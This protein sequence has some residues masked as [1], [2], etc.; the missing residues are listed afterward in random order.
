[1]RILFGFLVL[2]GM[3]GAAVAE[4]GRI[5]VSGHG[6]VDVT[7]DMAVLT[8]GVSHEAKDAGEAV[9]ETS[10]KAG[11]ILSRLDALGIEKRDVQ[12]S[13]L[14]LHPVHKRYDSG[15]DA[16][17]DAFRATNTVTVRVRDVSKLGTVLARVVQDGANQFNGLHFALQSPRPYEDDARRTAVA[18]ARAKAELYAAAAGVTLGDVLE[19]SEGGGQGPRPMPMMREAMMA[20]ASVPVAAGE[21]TV[22]A[23][24]TMVFS[25]SQ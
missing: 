2:V 15:N 13:N 14:T 5:V 7:P 21:L 3:C 16:K 11:E 9:S 20:D 19:I 17:I 25:V 8:L 10:A 22:R 18:D 4:P 1:M 23:Q 6:A 12:T 24:V